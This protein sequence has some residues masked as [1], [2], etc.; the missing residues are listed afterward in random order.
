MN[1]SATSS[2]RFSFSKRAR[3]CVDALDD[4]V[5]ERLHLG[6]GDQF[7]ARSEGNIVCPRPFFQRS[8]VGG[9][10]DGGEL[11]L[12]AKDGGGT[13]E[14]IQLERILDRLRRD[15]LAAGSLDQILLAVGDREISIG[16]NVADIA[17][18]EPA[19]DQR[20]I[21]VSSGRFQ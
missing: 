21:R 2:T 3:F 14:R 15:K 10:D 4:A 17:S 16:I 7:R 8:K 9:D 12:V 6:M 20:G 1:S 18:L 13:D 11:A 19:I 5:V